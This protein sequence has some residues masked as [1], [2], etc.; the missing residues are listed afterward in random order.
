MT[1]FHLKS[2]AWLQVG[3]GRLGGS[4]Y[5]LSGEAGD[6]GKGEASFTENCGVAESQILERRN[7]GV[8]RLGEQMQSLRF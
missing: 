4:S 2:E 1:S 8:G 7:M 3:E 5:H 6:G